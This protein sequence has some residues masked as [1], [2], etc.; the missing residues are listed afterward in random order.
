MTSQRKY[1]IWYYMVKTT[2][3]CVGRIATGSIAERGL[4]CGLCVAYLNIAE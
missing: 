4:L 2:A 1:L 3:S